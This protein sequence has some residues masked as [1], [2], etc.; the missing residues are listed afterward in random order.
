MSLV[1]TLACIAVAFVAGFVIARARRAPAAPTSPSAV[2][3]PVPSAARPEPAAPAAPIA[4]AASAPDDAALRTALV[5]EARLVRSYEAEATALRRAIVGR[6]AAL[7]QLA[8]FAA[9]RR[10]LFD[11]VAQARGETA[12]YR[13]LVVDLE[14]NA[15]PPLLDGPGAPD[16]LKL[17][18]G[19]GPV[20]ER[21]LHQLGVT[22]YRQIARWTERDVVEFDA[23][24]PEFPGRIR[25]DAWVTQARE[26]HQSKYGEA[27]PPRE[28]G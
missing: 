22:T 8:A 17:I 7:A 5:E 13:Q 24:L 15:P 3:E 12:R 14:N 26:L 28:R 6:D 25:R 18:V 16:D 20:L 4:A 19:V 1:F 23:R 11:E 21:M 9:E 2:A 27:L 10:R